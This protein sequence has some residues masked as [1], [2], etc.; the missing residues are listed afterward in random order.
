MAIEAIKP[1]DRVEISM[2]IR[3]PINWNAA[4]K[5]KIEEVSNKSGAIK[6]LAPF[7][8]RRIVMLPKSEQ[9][10]VRVTTATGMFIYSAAVAGM[11]KENGLDFALLKLAGDGTK[12]QRRDFFRFNCAIPI[13]FFLLNEDGEPLDNIPKEGLIR[14]MSGG[15]M[16]ML[17]KEII[18]INTLLRLVLQ[19]DRGEL[20]IF[21]HVLRKNDNPNAVHPYQY[22]LKFTAMSSAEQDKLVQYIYQEQRKSM[23][24]D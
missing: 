9:C 21:G 2:I 23:Q 11:V 13:E 5:S 19:M 1:G 18:K 17:S 16:R 4:Y 20:M 14:D 15:G 22:H 12:T 24:R 8:E 6:I 3:A 7:H 10:M